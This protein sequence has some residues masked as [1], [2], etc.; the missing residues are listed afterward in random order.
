LL[1]NTGGEI[2]YALSSIDN[3]CRRGDS[4]R[5]PGQE[6]YSVSYGGFAGYHAPL[7]A[8]KDLGL[9]TNHGLNA[10]PVMI[11]GS[12]RGMQAL[13]SG[14]THFALADAT[15]PVSALYQGADVVLVAS[16]MNKFPFSMY[17]QKEITR[18]P[19]SRANESASPVSAEPRNGGLTWH[20]ENGTSR[21]IQSRSP[22]TV[23]VPTGFWGCRPEASMRLCWRLR[24]RPRQSA[25]ACGFSAI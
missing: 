14:S 23:P 2:I 7:W 18:T 19:T 24:N 10:D 17:A 9:F 16:A 3:P 11:A 25:K 8:A 20:S 4:V 21:A 12:A 6:R 22:L 1:N 15:G 13:L 5:L